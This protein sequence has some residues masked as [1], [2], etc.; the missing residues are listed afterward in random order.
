MTARER[1]LSSS[2]YEIF[3][4]LARQKKINTVIDY[5]KK[6]EEIV[7]KDEGT[8]KGKKN[9]ESSYNKNDH[10][11]SYLLDDV[12]G[13]QWSKTLDNILEKTRI[14]DGTKLNDFL[15][16]LG[17][18]VGKTN[19]NFIEW[20]V[21]GRILRD[22]IL[23][24]NYYIL[25]IIEGMD[26]ITFFNAERKNYTKKFIDQ[27][28]KF[29]LEGYLSGQTSN[30]ENELLLMTMRESTFKEIK[31]T[32]AD[33][34]GL[35]EIV[36]KNFENFSKIYQDTDDVSQTISAKKHD[37]FFEKRNKYQK[38]CMKKVL[39]AINDRLPGAYIP[40]MRDE[41][42]ISESIINDMVWNNN[43]RCMLFNR[44][45]LAKFI[46]YRYYLLSD[47]REGKTTF[48]I[49]KQIDNFAETHLFLNGHLFVY[50]KENTP[51]G[52]RGVA[53]FNLFGY[54]NGNEKPNY[55]IYTYILL[56]T[57]GTV[58]DQL[59]Y[60]SIIISAL[61]CFNGISAVDCERCLERLESS[62][63]ICQEYEYGKE[64]L[65]KITPKG[66]FFLKKF[67]NN[68][69][70]LYYSSID[71]LLPEK[72]VHELQISP[73]NKSFYED[74]RD[75]N[76]LPNCVITGIL[77]LRCLI[78]KHKIA[79]N[80]TV[81]RNL[82]DGGIDSSIFKLPIERENLVKLIERIIKKCSSGQVDILTNWLKTI[83]KD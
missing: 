80:E 61:T 5:L 41:N 58:Q 6:F 77:F 56:L 46:T 44:I 76:Y 21:I 26:N 55:F 1:K 53:C 39:S 82:E 9:R 45:N 35:P 19:N 8:Y 16:N 31:H 15:K 64:M 49:D 10:F 74:D 54:V 3:Q 51:I 37:V 48:D 70:Y 81:K 40:D 69:H 78:Y 67:Y 57:Q 83:S 71:T 22:F 25:Y 42:K 12:L 29:P 36:L 18:P 52:N 62:G 13:S 27:L 7:A 63:M 28:Y 38:T 32:F 60:H 47:L 59:K 75:R 73:N 66:E 2:D 24:N 30:K 34:Y 43:L 4:A 11:K 65:Y 33:T 23:E 72:L 20:M 14:E 17:F 79:L 68:I 50:E